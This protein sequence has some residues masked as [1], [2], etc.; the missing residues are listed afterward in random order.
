MSKIVKVIAR[1]IID[2][3]GN[4]TVEVDVY[5]EGGAMGRAAVPSGASTGEHAALE[6][7]LRRDALVR[8]GGVLGKQLALARHRG[9]ERRRQVRRQHPGGVR[10]ERQHHHR[11]GLGS[12]RELV[13]PLQQ[14]LV[15]AVHPVEV[16]DDHDAPAREQRLHRVDLTAARQYEHAALSAS[17][18]H[19]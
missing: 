7:D 8:E 17:S 19:L 13:G 4:P 5:I 10:R 6:L 14:R 12:H 9:D 11:A 18:A 15:A 2:S 3:R 16:A 1:E